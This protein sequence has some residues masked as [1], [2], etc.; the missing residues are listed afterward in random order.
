M[1][2]TYVVGG[3]GA[4]RRVRARYPLDICKNS[5]GMALLLSAE[6]AAQ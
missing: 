6:P 2:R 4:N 1:K 3:S 5:R